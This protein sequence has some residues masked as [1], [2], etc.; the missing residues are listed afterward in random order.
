MV[1]RE[2]FLFLMLTLQL[3]PSSAPSCLRRWFM[4]GRTLGLASFKAEDAIGIV[5]RRSTVAEASATL[6]K[7]LPKTSSDEANETFAEGSGEGVELKGKKWEKFSQAQ[8]L[9]GHLRTVSTCPSLGKRYSI[10]CREARG[11][12][13]TPNGRL[14]KRLEFRL[15]SVDSAA[16]AGFGSCYRRSGTARLTGPMENIIMSS[17]E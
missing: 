11:N 1:L 15:F 8:S 16:G 17:N 13:C 2:T 4:M 6:N 3:L 14:Y 9:S 12:S 7:L 10:G 5:K